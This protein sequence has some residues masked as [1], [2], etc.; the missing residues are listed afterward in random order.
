MNRFLT[1]ALIAAGMPSAD[2]A[3]AENVIRF[4]GPGQLF[5]SQGQLA[6][7]PAHSPVP[8]SGNVP[9]EPAPSAQPVS[10]A[11]VR[12]VMQPAVR[13]PI[14]VA[15]APSQPTG[16]AKSGS[17]SADQNNPIRLHVSNPTNEL[18]TG[19]VA[20][21]DNDDP[22]G[23]ENLSIEDPEPPS[24]EQLA[25][26]YPSDN[27]QDATGATKDNPQSKDNLDQRRPRQ[28]SP[29]AQRNGEKK[30]T[31][32]QVPRNALPGSRSTQ[33]A[34][35][36]HDRET[37]PAD[38]GQRRGDDT[39]AGDDD[40]DA[41]TNRD[42][43]EPRRLGGQARPYTPAPRN[44][45]NPR[46]HAGP[47]YR[48]PRD[49]PRL[50]PASIFPN[51]LNHNP[52]GS[53]GVAAPSSK[54]G[55][56]HA[57][58]AHRGYGP[59]HGES[60]GPECG[61]RCGHGLLRRPIV[62][63]WHVYAGG[64]YMSRD[65]GTNRSLSVST[66]SP[67]PL[68]STRS[69]A[70]DEAGGFE[71]AWGRRSNTGGGWE[72]G[73]WGLFPEDEFASATDPNPPG[74][75]LPDLNTTLDF[76]TLD[77]D[78]G[79]VNQSA[80]NFFNSAQH[81]ALRSSFEFNNVELNFFLP[82][83]FSSPLV[84]AGWI[85]GLRIFNFNEDFA[86]VSDPVNTVL[87]DDPANELEY[88]IDVEN[89]LVGA[90]L[91]YFWDR[92]WYDRLR[93][94]VT[95]KAGIYGNDINYRTRVGNLAGTAVVNTGP[96]SGQAFDIST[97]SD[98]VAFIGEADLGLIYDISRRWSFAGGYRIT[99]LDGVA[100]TADQVATNFNNLAQVSQINDSGSL[101]LHGAYGHLIF[102]W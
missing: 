89:R 69:V 64:L 42:T 100:L 61:G 66:A 26:S 17:D 65:N 35:S 41:G 16:T 80:D 62:S 37:G 43:L 20:I 99:V 11:K 54:L 59:G 56:S 94:N 90:Q 57:P 3:R 73:Y 70:Q 83:R 84:R 63:G 27:T 98:T 15:R 78:N 51:N 85:G 79:T 88:S 21:P 4:A 31:A 55:Y 9:Q 25:P 75:V 53:Y 93:T 76:S 5:V 12:F 86:F 39:D 45:A 67:T 95:A 2:Q 92:R 102:H 68:L 36:A 48:D 50:P 30:K 1:I 24:T 81:H 13:A 29:E 19:R 23:T 72:V 47:R 97:G 14:R 101:V 82:T 71:I 77:F 38:R 18:E 91:G 33:D 87:G 46:V 10:R 60:C 34:P 44:D 6:L 8:G 58:F 40:D 28:P 7:E 96:F 22:A 74:A 32:A 49:A 52:Y